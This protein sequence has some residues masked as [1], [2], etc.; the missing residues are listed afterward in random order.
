MP[1]VL[2]GRLKYVLSPQFNIYEKISGI[3]S[4]YVA[5]IGFGTGFGTHLLSVRADNVVGFEIDDDAVAFAQRA[6]PFPKLQFQHGNIV[7]GIPGKYDFVTMIDVLEHIEND[8]AALVN[9][10]AI[11]KPG[12]ILI[13]STP[14]KHSRYGKSDTHSREYSPKELLFLLEK[15]FPHVSLRNYNLDPHTKY[16]NPIVALCS[17]VEIEEG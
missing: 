8:H 4:G 14:N 9:A 7:D 17:N 6:F 16:D 3:M 11:L 13:I 2:W 10:E 5:D 12:G 1:N 15:Y